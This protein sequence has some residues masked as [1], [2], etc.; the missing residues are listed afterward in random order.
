[1]VL[2]MS[3]EVFVILIIVLLLFGSTAI[4]KLARA[5]GKAKGEFNE[6]KKE[7]DREMA[8]AEQG[9]LTST[10]EDAIRKTASEL[11][12]E[13]EGRSIEDIK[14]DLKRRLD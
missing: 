13:T 2:G 8:K 12:I 5:M 10:S 4:P 3:N 11:G 14:A 7:F 6:A 9:Q 1:M